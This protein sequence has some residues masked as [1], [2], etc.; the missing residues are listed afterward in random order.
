MRAAVTRP[1]PS[2]MKRQSQLLLAL[3]ALCTPSCREPPPSP[4]ATADTAT[5]PS[6]APTPSAPPVVSAGEPTATNS[7][8]IPNSPPRIELTSVD[9]RLV[10][11]LHPSL[12]PYT[13][14]VTG[15]ITPGG[16]NG[17]KS[18]VTLSGPAP[19]GPKVVVEAAPGREQRLARGPDTR[20]N[21]QGFGMTPDALD[22][23]VSP[24]AGANVGAGDL[25]LADF[26]LDG[27]LDVEIRMGNAHK[28]YFKQVWLFNP[29]NGLF[30]ELVQVRDLP[31][32]S[33]A[34][35]GCIVSNSWWAGGQNWSFFEV[36]S[37]RLAQLGWTGYDYDDPVGVWESSGPF[38]CSNVPKGARMKGA[39][40]TGDAGP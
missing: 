17:E 3:A 37:R 33:L 20:D 16:R 5:A 30:E 14:I 2:P 13:F 25:A 10:A 8:A 19:S 35:K 21:Y 40:P 29:N 6:T 31:N 24:T 18:R 26:D 27:Y 22:L 32:V 7:P 23:A 36:R 11:S 12:P 9:W 38:R 39:A 34:S 28:Y 4:V 15:K 1:R